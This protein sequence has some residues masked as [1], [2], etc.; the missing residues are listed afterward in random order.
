MKLRCIRILYVFGYGRN[1]V[2]CGFLSAVAWSEGCVAAPLHATPPRDR[3]TSGYRGM[4]T[5]HPT[6]AQP[7]HTT[8]GRALHHTGLRVLIH[9]T[10]IVYLQQ[11]PNNSVSSNTS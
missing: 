6:T 9:L 2:P 11:I 1:N 10:T 3:S 5:P 4:Q 8:Q 7:H